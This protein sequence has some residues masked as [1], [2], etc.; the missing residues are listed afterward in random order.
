MS[1]VQVGNG[2]FNTKTLRY[3]QYNPQ[4]GQMQTSLVPIDPRNIDSFVQ[5]LQSGQYKIQ[6]YIRQTDSNFLGGRSNVNV[7][8]QIYE[9]AKHIRAQY[10]QMTQESALNYANKWVTDR[11]ARGWDANEVE[12][13]MKDIGRGENSINQDFLQGIV[14]D[15]NFDESQATPGGTTGVGE[16]NPLQSIQ[17]E[18][19]A[20][21]AQMMQT[22]G[23]DSPQAKRIAELSAQAGN[24]YA[25]SS[26]MG[27]GGITA[28][29]VAATAARAHTDLQTQRESIGLQALA[30]AGNQQLTVD[31]AKTALQQQQ[32]QAGVLNASGIGGLI[33][34]GLG[35]VG[36][37]VGSA[38]TYGAMAPAI[39][40]FMQAGG[41]AGQG[42]GGIVGNQ[43]GPIQYGG[44]QAPTSR[45]TGRNW[46]TS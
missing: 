37:I 15:I 9:A 24:R 29:G 25:T 42:I 23:P 27:P 31:A 32:Q 6:D 39:P 28:R 21:A 4:T 1:T 40:G 35:L 22:V 10:P 34:S 12:N 8:R 45:F 33:G 43:Q 5:G 7:S 13:L 41:A 11:I 14:G 2:W 30:A 26:G 44:Q 46:G 19:R 38:A 20:F 17:D 18:L 36:G 16:D 3:T